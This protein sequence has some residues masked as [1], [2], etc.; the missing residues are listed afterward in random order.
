L[1]KVKYTAWPNRL[2]QAY[3][4]PEIHGVVSTEAVSAEVVRLLSDSGEHRKMVERLKS[5]VGD[6]GA[7]DRLAQ[8][9]R[10][11]LKEKF[12]TD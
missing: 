9:V 6:S 2:A 4:V 11:V 3:V 8:L 1:A 10:E 7:A 12:G 5:M